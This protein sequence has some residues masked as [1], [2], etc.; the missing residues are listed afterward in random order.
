MTSNEDIEKQ[1]V[2]ITKLSISELS[3]FK[4]EVVNESN[5]YHESL[6]NLKFARLKFEEILEVI[7]SLSP[8]QSGK[9]TLVPLTPSMYV[10]GVVNDAGNVMIDIGTGYFIKK[11]IK[12][13][14]GYFKRK[15]EFLDGQISKLEEMDVHRSRLKEAL[16]SILEAKLQGHLA[17]QIPATKA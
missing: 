6:V 14:Q 16:S 17:E 1:I 5:M 13:A 10:P 8:N 12:G 2:D 7:E 9:K 3:Q 11:D 4:Q 15:L